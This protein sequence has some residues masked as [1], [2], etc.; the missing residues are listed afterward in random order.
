MAL[1][2]QSEFNDWKSHSVTKAFF[3]AAQI[4]IDECKDV[5]S[6]SAGIDHL[7]DRQLVGL[8]QA[9]RELFD[10][11]IEDIVDGN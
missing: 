6:Y 9:Y 4:R 8:I 3:E 11:R 7:Q 10:F 2:N 5:L 1:I